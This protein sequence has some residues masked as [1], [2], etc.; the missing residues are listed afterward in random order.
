MANIRN[1]YQA[2]VQTT[3]FDPTAPGGINP[4]W[5][6]HKPYTGEV[7]PDPEGPLNPDWQDHKP[8]PEGGV[9]Q[10]SA[11]TSY[12]IHAGREADLNDPNDAWHAFLT[13]G[14]YGAPKDATGAKGLADEFNKWGS[15][16]GWSAQVGPG[17]GDKWTF[18]N[19]NTGLQD[20]ADVISNIGG[21]GSG[22][23]Y[24]SANFPTGGH[25]APPGGDGNGA[26]SGTGTGPG[27]NGVTGDSL[28]ATIAKLFPGGLFNQDIVNRRTE[29]AGATLRRAAQSRKA[30]NKAIMGERG[31]LGSGPE[32][33]S[34]NRV[35][36]DIDDRYNEA[37]SGIY[38]NESENADQRMIQALGLATGMETA[39]LDRA[40]G[41]LR[42]NNDFSLGQGGLALG[43]MKAQNEYNLGLGNFG[44]NRDVAK[45]N[46]ERG[47]VD[48][49][50]QLLQLLLGGANTSSGGHF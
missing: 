30:N 20:Q 8:L 10:G 48:Q 49:M 18:S 33:S 14:Q 9:Q 1:R 31:Q 15:Q 39:D 32:Y 19:K 34:E 2:P 3:E 16:Y 26:G 28:R 47:D 24:G 40:L 50:L 44:L 25:N 12:K 35:N 27:I 38:A 17:S 23:W 36:Q 5:Q 22:L 41:Y 6:D 43:N 46:M 13:T 4:D 45:Y 42:A 7:T 11:P 21:Q 37:V 29:N